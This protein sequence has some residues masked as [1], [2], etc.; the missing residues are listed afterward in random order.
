MPN[1]SP[2]ASGP[3]APDATRMAGPGSSGQSGQTALE[4]IIALGIVAAMTAVLWQGA[5]R[6]I[7]AQA[8]IRAAVRASAAALMADSAIRRGVERLKPPFWL[9]LVPGKRADGGLSAIYADGRPDKSLEIGFEGDSLLVRIEGEPGDRVAGVSDLAFSP[10]FAPGGEAVG[11]V[12]RYTCTGAGT[13]ETKALFG[14]LPA[15]RPR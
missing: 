2:R 13:F 1:R 11:V 8:R 15:R 10:F 3:E 9:R 4:A 5:T 6:M 12:V 7:D 14:G